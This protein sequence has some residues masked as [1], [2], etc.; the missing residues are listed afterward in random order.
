MFGIAAHGVADITRRYT[1][2]EPAQ[3]APR[4]TA[5]TEVALQQALLSITARLRA[6]LTPEIRVALEQRD[7]AEAAA[8]ARGP[9][10]P[11]APLPGR[12]TGSVAWRSQ[13]GVCCI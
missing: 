10:T 1:T 7:L 6:D 9:C 5:M 12:T 8:L 4:R 11:V 3:L 13:R 2:L